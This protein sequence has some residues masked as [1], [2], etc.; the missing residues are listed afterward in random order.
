MRILGFFLSMVCLLL[1]SFAYYLQYVVGLEPCPL[2]ILQRSWYFLAAVFALFI[3]FFPKKHR[4]FGLLG[5]ISVSIGLATAG[6]Q[7]WLQYLPKEKVPACGPGLSYMLE[8]FPMND[9]LNALLHGSGECAEIQ[10]S[11]LHLSLGEWSLLAFVGLV[12][13]FIFIVFQKRRRPS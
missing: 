4:I 5:L 12:I 11:W 3:G 10:W 7:V 1:L 2:C 9:L 8:K 13:A 6:R